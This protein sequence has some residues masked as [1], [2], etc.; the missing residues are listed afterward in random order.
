MRCSAVIILP[1]KIKPR[2]LT[3][4]LLF[5]NVLMTGLKCICK[6]KYKIFKTMKNQRL[7]ILEAT[8]ST[9]ITIQYLFLKTNEELCFYGI[10]RSQEIK[11]WRISDLRRSEF[12]TILMS[13]ISDIYNTNICELYTN[14]VTEWCP[15]CEILS[16]DVALSFAAL[17]F[18]PAFLSNRVAWITYTR[19]SGF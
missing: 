1:S 2:I 5:Y 19:N 12:L 15:F 16:W 13:V 3:S 18:Y 7:P 4:S 11:Y 17:T 9:F 10:F 14:N 8:Y 6:Y